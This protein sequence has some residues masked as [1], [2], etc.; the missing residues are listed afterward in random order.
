MGH[1]YHEKVFS[2]HTSSILHGAGLGCWFNVA[3]SAFATF[4]LEK[5]LCP[6]ALPRTWQ[7]FSCWLFFFFKNENVFV[8]FLIIKLGNVFLKNS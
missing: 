5:C 3:M 6:S 8:S 7:N 1:E 4:F 2:V